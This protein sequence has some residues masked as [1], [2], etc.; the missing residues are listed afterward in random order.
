MQWRNIKGKYPA[1]EFDLLMTNIDEAEKYINGS[2]VTIYL[3]PEN[4]HRVH[5][6]MDGKLITLKYFPGNLFSVNNETIS[7]IPK[8]NGKIHGF[9]TKSA[10]NSILKKI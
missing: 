2:F 9:V 7:V 5:A 8:L 1:Y 10:V 6:P 3:A 4:Y